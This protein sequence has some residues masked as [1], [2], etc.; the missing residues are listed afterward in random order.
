MCTSGKT[1]QEVEQ[2]NANRIHINCAVVKPFEYPTL[3]K[4]LE[5]AKLLTNKVILSQ[6]CNR[7]TLSKLILFLQKKSVPPFASFLQETGVP[8][9]LTSAACNKAHQIRRCWPYIISN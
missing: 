4:F 9:H 6:F 2:Y 3:T 7:Q 1:P 5:I 8:L